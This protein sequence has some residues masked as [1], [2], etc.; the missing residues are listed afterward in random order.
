V[1]E[2]EGENQRLE[3]EVERLGL[4][5]PQQGEVVLKGDDAK[6]WPLF[7]AMGKPE[8]VK[9]QLDELPTLRTTVFRIMNAGRPAADYLLTS[10]CRSATSRMIEISWRI[11]GTPVGRERIGGR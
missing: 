5:I 11:A 10:S 1:E 4:L 6:A 8:D 7:K 2:L 9:K 3:G